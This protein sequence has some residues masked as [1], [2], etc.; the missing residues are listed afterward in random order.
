MPFMGFIAR[1]LCCGEGGRL[2]CNHLRKRQY[3][4]IGYQAMMHTHIADFVWYT[5]TSM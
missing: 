5:G 2:F 1:S 4:I 3:R